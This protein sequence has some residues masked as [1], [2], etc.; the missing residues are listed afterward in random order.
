MAGREGG[1]PLPPA[2]PTRRRRRDDDGGRSRQP[3]TNTLP[4]SSGAIFPP[5]QP[6]TSDQNPSEIQP[7][8]RKKQKSESKPGPS[9]DP[10]RSLKRNESRL[11][12]LINNF[13]EEVVDTIQARDRFNDRTNIEMN[14]VLSVAS[15]NTESVRIE[16][17]QSLSIYAYND[18][19]ERFRKLVEM[20]EKYI[21]RKGQQRRFK[22]RLPVRDKSTLKGLI[23]AKLDILCLKITDMADDTIDS[24]DDVR[25]TAWRKLRD[26][27][28]GIKQKG[29]HAVLGKAYQMF[30]DILQSVD[31]ER[32]P[33]AEIPKFVSA[34]APDPHAAFR[35]LDECAA[36][37][38]IGMFVSLEFEPIVYDEQR[39]QNILDI[40][41]PLE[42]DEHGQTIVHIAAQY[43]N[44]NT[45]DWMIDSGYDINHEDNYGFTPLFYA[46]IAN[47][48]TAVSVLIKNNV[49]INHAAGEMGRKPI[50][51]AAQF[52][53]LD[54]MKILIDHGANIDS[55]DNNFHTPIII[56][57][58]YSHSEI[59]AFL[60]EE[61]A[62]PSIED[63]LGI[64]VAMRIAYTMPAIT[65]E[66]FNQF[67]SEDIYQGERYYK[68]DKMCGTTSDTNTSFYHYLVWL[69]NMGLIEHPM[70]ER[71][72]AAKWEIFGRKRANIKL[73]FIGLYL[74]I[75]SLL[76]VMGYRDFLREGYRFTSSDTFY[77]IVL[78]TSLGAFIWRSKQNFK[79]LR[80][81]YAYTASLSNLFNDTYKDEL[82]HLHFKGKKMT[83]F[84]H[85][86]YGKKAIT[87]FDDVKSS[88]AVLLDFVV[89][90]TLLIYLILNL[91]CSL[92]GNLQ[93]DPHQLGTLNPDLRP[94]TGNNGFVTWVDIYGAISLMALWIT[95][96]FKLQITK[97]V[98]PFVVYMRYCGK[99]L[100]TI[101]TMFI[102]LYIPAFCVFYKTAFCND[103]WFQ[104]MFL[105]LRMVLVDYDYEKGIRD[106][107]VDVW[108]MLLSMG[109]IIVSSVIVLNLLIALMADS[110][111]RIYETAELYARIERARFIMEYERTIPPKQMEEF[112]DLIK[113][114]SP[115][116]VIF[117][118]VCDRDKVS[119]IEETV[120]GLTKKFDKLERYMENKLLKELN[121]R[122]DTID[123]ALTLY[124]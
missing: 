74:F 26:A 87:F 19:I 83:H 64:M 111:S 99:D 96:F 49:I 72:T 65:R 1:P 21:L 17:D 116:I 118:P 25:L 18:P 102:A 113:L 20:N 13:V 63:K 30:G 53:C 68:L 119:V 7:A 44:P 55:L 114:E 112:N 48:T 52:G 88:P 122:L 104:G 70:F 60:L 47:N 108:W 85:R 98:G 75:W 2:M 16:V 82:K 84:L 107:P 97:K 69:A 121:H 89:D 61:G 14:E 40:V 109:W 37:Q 3:R 54:T 101:A 12:R 22:Q 32:I 80:Q 62:N 110:Y 39:L 90:Q 57:S 5:P 43:C 33:I 76:Y 42:Q 9:Q 79:L 8:P 106:T 91:I 66:V 115:Q 86:K 67:V 24:V 10:K 94:L 117:D 124:T 28:T 71:L 45:L 38:G 100:S 50:H 58:Y 4:S 120:E 78:F 59:S 31:D 6:T 27:A 103:H 81:R 95:C 56:S 23:Q 36:Q 51:I 41:D 93:A 92:V 46:V 15:S 29:G 123:Q 77:L 35:Y 105:V 73:S 34:D 11:N